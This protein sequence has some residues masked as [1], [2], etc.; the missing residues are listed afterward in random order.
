M[1]LT[2][3]TGKAASCIRA[4]QEAALASERCA[5]AC[6]HESGIDALRRCIALDLDNAEV[7]RTT[8]YLL[9]HGSALTAEMCGVCIKSCEATA[10]EGEKH[11]HHGHCQENARA[12]RRAVEELTRYVRLRD[13]EARAAA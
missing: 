5:H 2:E 4:C 7:C 13:G 3:I 9:A 10:A 6:L 8:V 1:S 11:A 12:C